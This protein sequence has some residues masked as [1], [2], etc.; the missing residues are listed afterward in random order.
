[1]TARTAGTALC[2]LS[3]ASYGAAGILGKLA[4]DEGLAVTTLLSAR[5]AIAAVVLWGLVA[6]I[7]T[8]ARPSRRGLIAGV[9]LGLAVYA[10]Q[11]GLFFGSLTRLDAAMT[12]LIV[13]VAPAFVAGAAALLGREHLRPAQLVALP[14]ALGGVALVATGA[15]VGT[16]DGLGVVFALLCAVVYSAYILLSD[17]VVQK[18]NPVPL[19]ASVCTGAAISFAVAAT[20]RG[21][22]PT[23][24]SAPGWGTIVALAIISTVVSIT[25]LAAG[26]ARVG[27]S[28]A[29]ILSTFEPVV[30]TTLAFVILGETLTALQMLGGLIVVSAVAILHLGWK[31]PP[32][33]AV[34]RGAP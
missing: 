27:P 16:I 19:S 25:A 1:M 9:L 10:P 13:Y 32:A 24:V 18:V 6:L 7:G 17:A 33:E 15:G 21:E 23:S 3:A 34:P 29:A 8:T 11:S 2:L 26:T 12:V 4:Y 30:A 20:L 22:L 14:I 28:T 31:A 5:F